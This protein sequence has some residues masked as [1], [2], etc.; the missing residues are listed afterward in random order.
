MG[1]PDFVGGGKGFIDLHHSSIHGDLLDDLTG[2][3]DIILG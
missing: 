2:D 3:V 1:T